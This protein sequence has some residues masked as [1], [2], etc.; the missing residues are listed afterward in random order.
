[1]GRCLPVSHVSPEPAGFLR[2]PMA[3]RGAS[4][5]PPPSPFCSHS[6]CPWRDSLATS[7]TAVQLS[8]FVAALPP[9]SQALPTRP[10]RRPARPHSHS[11]CPR[12]CLAKEGRLP[13]N[14]PPAFHPQP[15]APLH[16]HL[17][18]P[19]SSWVFL[20]PL[21]STFRVS[22]QPPGVGGLRAAMAGG[23]APL[24]PRWVF[25]SLFPFTSPFPLERASRTGT[26]ECTSTSCP[27]GGRQVGWEP[28]PWGLAWTL[29]MSS[30]QPLSLPSSL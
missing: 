27:L 16:A 1:M 26:G 29:T 28:D 15:A 3:G 17:P 25:W 4:P 22:H 23:R 20:L 13:A 11:V 8:D 14:C 12:L 5:H 30:C 24:L 9:A 2:C 21:L 18:V 10:P 19:A 7:S 6:F